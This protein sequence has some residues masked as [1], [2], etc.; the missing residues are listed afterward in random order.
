MMNELPKLEDLGYTNELPYEL[1][2]DGIKFIR[3]SFETMLKC[4]GEVICSHWLLNQA[5]EP[6]YCNK[7][8]L[9]N[10][11]LENMGSLLT[12]FNC[13]SVLRHANWYVINDGIQHKQ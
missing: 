5:M 4:D 7:P 11:I 13:Q 8:M 10:I 1:T 9:L 3:V 2:F 12:A 6:Q